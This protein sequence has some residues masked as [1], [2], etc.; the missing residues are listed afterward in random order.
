MARA[1][2]TLVGILL[3]CAAAL[4]EP[5][6]SDEI[7]SKDTSAARRGH[8][9]H[10]WGSDPGL[11]PVMQNLVYDWKISDSRSKPVIQMAFAQPVVVHQ[12]IGADLK[13]G[14]EAEA[15]QLPLVVEK[16]FYLELFQF[17]DVK[18]LEVQG[19]TRDA[20]KPGQSADTFVEVTWRCISEAE[21]DALKPPPPSPRPPNPPPSPRPPPPPP[22]PSPSPPRPPPP[23]SQSPAPPSPSPPPPPPPPPPP[24]PS[25]SPPPPAPPPP[26][27]LGS[28][29]LAIGGLLATVAGAAALVLRRRQSED[30]DSDDDDSDDS[31][32]D[33][34]D[35]DDSDSDDGK[36]SSA[37]L[38]PA[39]EAEAEEEEEEEEAEEEELAKKPKPQSKGSSSKGSCSG[40][41]GK[42]T[43]TRAPKKKGKKSPIDIV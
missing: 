30:D 11:G 40:K 13:L 26:A 29:M 22:P 31:D 20:L 37:A 43:A 10:S 3:A 7:M 17:G 1:T 25:P 35:D 12:L 8:W 39:A 24:S 36:G 28:S 32:D 18:N 33:D 42:S 23:P 6:C 15:I 5:S 16:S 2:A 9:A 4:P 14:D 38:K 41:A 21:F 34:D 27:V 19:V